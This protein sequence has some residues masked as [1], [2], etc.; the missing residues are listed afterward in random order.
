MILTFNQRLFLAINRRSGQSAFF[1]RIMFVVAHYLLYPVMA[2]YFFWLSRYFGAD[3]FEWQALLWILAL[4]LSFMASYG[5]AVVWRHPR[6]VRELPQTK[7][8]FHTLGTW[9]SFPSDHSIAA[10]IPASLAFF[11]GAPLWFFA[12]LAF[13]CAV[14]GYARVY[15]GVHY[16]RDIAGGWLIG[17]LFVSVVNFLPL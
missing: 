7:L 11:A 8:L 12:L 14:L 3:E 17:A 9:K 1:D 2:G 16:P 5:V 4:L 13:G 10:A 6:P 15:A